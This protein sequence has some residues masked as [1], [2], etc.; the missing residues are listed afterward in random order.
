MLNS[1]KVELKKEIN[2]N[3]T[4]GEKRE[5]VLNFEL[6][7]NNTRYL[8]LLSLYSYTFLGNS[9]PTSNHQAISEQDFEVKT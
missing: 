4:A 8:S 3:Q 7:N 6:K 1:N 2:Y 5:K 9:V